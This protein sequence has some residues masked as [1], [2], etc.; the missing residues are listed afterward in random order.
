M[1]E[2]KEKEALDKN[3][4]IEWKTP[5]ED[6]DFD[7]L[8]NSNYIPKFKEIEDEINSPTGKFDN[9]TIAKFK[10]Y[11]GYVNVNQINR[12]MVVTGNISDITSNEVIIDVGGKDTITIERRGTEDKICKQLEVGKFID[13]LI[14]NVSENPYMIKGSVAE[15][16]KHKV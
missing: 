1:V 6:F 12:G 7:N 3:A 5:D 9:E 4:K 13:V 2:L 11:E 14:N 16:V 8:D 10:M 15:L